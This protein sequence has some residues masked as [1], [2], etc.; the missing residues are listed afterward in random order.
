M[1]HLNVVSISERLRDDLAS[2][3]RGAGS[4]P[5]EAWAYTRGSWVV[6]AKEMCEADALAS[7][8]V[9]TVLSE[10]LLLEC[11]DRWSAHPVDPF[12]PRK[13]RRSWKT[14]PKVIVPYS[15]LVREHTRRTASRH[16]KSVDDVREAVF[17]LALD[18]L[19]ALDPHS[20]DAQAGDA[21]L[22]EARAKVPALSARDKADL[23][24][25]LVD[26]LYGTRRPHPLAERIV[27]AI[28]Q[29]PEELAVWP[30]VVRLLLSEPEAPDPR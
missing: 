23:L 12:R 21:W 6:V 20:L 16:K 22:D 3:A 28:R 13:G 18:E 1:S 10:S 7:L 25:L 9:R 27:R 15:P 11:V 17:R 5:E 8:Y 29:H 14:S 24:R 2:R 30:D 19:R 4:T 26:D